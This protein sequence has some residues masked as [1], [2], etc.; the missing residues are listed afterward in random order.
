LPHPLT[1]LILTFRNDRLASTD[2]SSFCV[3][4]E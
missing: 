3:P 2:A 4:T 1:N